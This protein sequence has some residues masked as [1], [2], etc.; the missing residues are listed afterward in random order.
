[1]KLLYFAYGSN[2]DVEQMRQ[3]LRNPALCP[4]GLAE[5]RGWSFEF[6]KHSEKN[7]IKSD[8]ANIVA[9]PTGRVLGCLYDLTPEELDTLWQRYEKGYNIIDVDVFCDAG[10]QAAKTF[11]AERLCSEGCGPA[12]E[13]LDL[14]IKGARSVGL[15]EGYVDRIKS[16]GG[17]AG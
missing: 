8:K 3:R 7:G 11:V 6:N 17:S 10:R 16:L 2:L 12:Q 14:I 4:I 1:M 9:A 5:L 13:Y 15:A